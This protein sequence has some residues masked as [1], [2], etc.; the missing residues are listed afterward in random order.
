MGYIEVVRPSKTSNAEPVPSTSK[1][2]RKAEDQWVQGTVLL[3]AFKMA[4]CFLFI[5]EQ[6]GY[7][8]IRHFSKV[9]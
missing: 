4:N 2:Q 5:F 9:T 8:Y 6:F 3:N 1:T 7:S